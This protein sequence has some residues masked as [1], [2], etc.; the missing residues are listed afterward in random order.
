MDWRLYFMYWTIYFMKIM[1]TRDEL[2]RR[3]SMRQVTPLGLPQWFNG[4]CTTSGVI[5]VRPG[6][7]Q[8]P[9][10]HRRKVGGGAILG[11]NH[12]RKVGGGAILRFVSF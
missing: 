6:V 8:R 9:L 5:R 4:F 7:V 12:R 3:L 10:N 11:F 1:F 2:F